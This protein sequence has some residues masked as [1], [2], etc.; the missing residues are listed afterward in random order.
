[1]AKLY[2]LSGVA[3]FTSRRGKHAYIVQDSESE[4]KCVE[5]SSRRG[6]RSLM[7][8]ERL[9]GNLSGSLAADS[10]S[11]CNFNSR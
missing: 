1:M 4:R 10:R 3:G 7:L 9:I 11:V 2:E 6:G 8:N 5:S